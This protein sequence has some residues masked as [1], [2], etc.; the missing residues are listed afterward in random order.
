MKCLI[1]SSVSMVG[2]TSLGQ[3]CIFL[4]DHNKEHRETFDG[5]SY[6]EVNMLITLT[7]TQLCGA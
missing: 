5:F 2:I 3:C 4:Y 1:N 7:M 6:D